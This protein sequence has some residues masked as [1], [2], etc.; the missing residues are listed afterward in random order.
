MQSRWLQILL[1]VLVA[2]LAVL[3]VVTLFTGD[4]D[5][6]SLTPDE[7]QLVSVSQLEGFAD[8]APHPVYWVGE[9][10]DT[11]FE[12]SEGEDG[13][14]FVRYLPSDVGSETEFL[15]IAS[16]PVAD[17]VGALERTGEGEGK[18]IASS[19]NGAV[20]LLDTASPDNVHLAYP[21]EEVQIEVFSPV[22]REALEIASRD[23]VVP[24]P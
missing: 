9:R 2:I 5:E 15:T 12:L 8:D 13:R 19:D 20:I 23:Q 1:G 7:P 10:P 11:E 3:L 14:I 21:G 16:Y 18:E 6:V 4:D 17:P 24:V 22:P